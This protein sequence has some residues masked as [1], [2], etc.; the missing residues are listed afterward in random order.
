LDGAYRLD[1]L[2]NATISLA[3]SEIDKDGDNDNLQGGHSF[4]VGVQYG[5]KNANY[6]WAFLASFEHMMKA[7]T[8]DK[9]VS[10]TKKYKNDAHNALNLG[11]EL[12]TT[13]SEKSF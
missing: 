10:P 7:T 2:A 8:K 5:A 13:L 12:L 4:D 11:A 1:L 6:Q 3:D 9:S